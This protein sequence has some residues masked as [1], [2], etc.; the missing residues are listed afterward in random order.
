MLHDLEIPG[1]GIY[2]RAKKILSAVKNPPASAGGIGDSGSIA[3]L[4]KSPGGGNGNQ[5]QY[6]CLENSM[7][8]GT[9]WA[10]D[11]GVTKSRT[12]LSM[13]MWERK[14][15]YISRKSCISILYHVYSYLSKI[16]SHSYGHQWKTG[17]KKLWYIRTVEYCSAVFFLKK[18]PVNSYNNIDESQEQVKQ[19]EARHKTLSIMW[20][21]LC[22][23]QKKE[24]LVY[25]DRNQQVV[26]GDRRGLD[27]KQTHVNFLRHWRYLFSG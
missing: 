22:E 14:K 2:P 26:D 20:F 18:Q 12:Q 24:R 4:G 16:R 21:H 19:K 6:S 7:D 23:V 9:W 1:V 8:R 15:I 5:L 27:W 25:T 10:T 13:H 17:L 11:R 3:G